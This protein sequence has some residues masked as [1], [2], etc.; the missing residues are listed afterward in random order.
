MSILI[1]GI[2]SLKDGLYQIQDGKIHAYKGNGGKTEGYYLIEV[3]PHGPLI[4]ADKLLKK[5]INLSWSVQKWV[6]E[7]D[8]GTMRTIIEAEEGAEE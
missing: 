7:V 5:G 8:I 4:D 1:K 6:S 3:P 2:S